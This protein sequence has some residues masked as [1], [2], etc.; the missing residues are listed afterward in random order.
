MAAAIA[1]PASAAHPSAATAAAPVPCRR[2][3]RRAPPLRRFGGCVQFRGRGFHL[4]PIGAGIRWRCVEF[5]AGDGDCGIG[6]AAAVPVADASAVSAAR[7]VNGASVDRDGADGP[8]GICSVEADSSLE[9]SA[10]TSDGGSALSETRCLGRG[11]RLPR[12]HTPRS[13]RA[14]RRAPC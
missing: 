5:A 9:P 1:A 4:H 14:R 3:C 11:R 13:G 10:K 6:A 12:R 8:E 2:S 7:C